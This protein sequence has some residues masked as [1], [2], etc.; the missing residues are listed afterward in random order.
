MNELNDKDRKF[1]R[2]GISKF[3]QPTTNR[4]IAGKESCG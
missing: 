2:Q 1:Y 3:L 4:C